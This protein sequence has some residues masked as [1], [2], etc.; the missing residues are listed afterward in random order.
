MFNEIPA[1]DDEDVAVF[2][3]EAEGK[4]REEYDIGAGAGDDARCGLLL[5]RQLPSVPVAQLGKKRREKKRT[6][7]DTTPVGFVEEKQKSKQTRQVLKID[8]W[9][10]KRCST[11]VKKDKYMDHLCYNEWKLSSS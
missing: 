10:N 5:A 2:L 1:E 6:K 4:R 7:I 8:T 11:P 9:A 3:N